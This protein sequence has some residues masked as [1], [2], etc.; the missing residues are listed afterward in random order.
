MKH[1]AEMTRAPQPAQSNALCTSPTS[2]YQVFL[3]FFISALT[4]FLLPVLGLK[5]P[6]GGGTEDPVDTTE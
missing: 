3:C 4:D 1:L 6:S 2:D 5:T